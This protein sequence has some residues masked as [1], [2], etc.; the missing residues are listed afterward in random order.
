VAW[1][2]QT[3]IDHRILATSFGT[4]HVDEAENCLATSGVIIE[5]HCVTSGLAWRKYRP[6]QK[7]K[8]WRALHKFLI[9]L[10]Q[11]ITHHYLALCFLVLYRQ[12]SKQLAQVVNK[13]S[14]AFTS[15]LGRP[16]ALHNGH[17]LI[18]ATLSNCIR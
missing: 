15:P 1:I 10:P 16:K 6:I 2:E 18:R 9:K 5:S 13:T 3:T 4:R 11:N 8:H 12:A 17:Y 7:W 14:Q